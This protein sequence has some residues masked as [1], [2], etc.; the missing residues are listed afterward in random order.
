MQI[1][2]IYYSEPLKQETLQ[3]I[4]MKPHALIVF[5]LMLIF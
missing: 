5:K 1:V 3:K 4:E 2:E